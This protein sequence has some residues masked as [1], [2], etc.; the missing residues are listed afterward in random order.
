MSSIEQYAKPSLKYL[1]AWIGKPKPMLSI[2]H[3]LA[4]YN[5][6]VR[7]DWYGFCFKFFFSL[8]LFCPVS[9]VP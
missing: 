7:F 1:L 3:V 6:L 8:Q 4:H 5:R 2:A 9:F